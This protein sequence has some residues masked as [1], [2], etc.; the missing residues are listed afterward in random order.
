M[1]IINALNS[2]FLTILLES[3]VYLSLLPYFFFILGML[4]LPF[5]I[6]YVIPLIHFNSL[7]LISN[8]IYSI[9]ILIQ[10]NEHC[11]F[12][13]FIILIKNSDF[14]KHQFSFSITKLEKNIITLNLKLIK[15]L[16]Q[17]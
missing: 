14:S 16:H 17:A 8:Q 4:L 11:L 3:K 13:L 5:Q 2:P 7:N 10:S 9:F 6:D 1:I 15:F 12:K